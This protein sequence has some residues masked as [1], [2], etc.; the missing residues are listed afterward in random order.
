MIALGDSP[1]VDANGDAMTDS[2]TPMMRALVAGSLLLATATL[3]VVAVRTV[4]A[5]SAGPGYGPC[6]QIAGEGCFGRTFNL[7]PPP[8]RTAS[9]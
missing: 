4:G 6:V 2:F 9:K 8:L 5:S 7:A 3:M 1:L